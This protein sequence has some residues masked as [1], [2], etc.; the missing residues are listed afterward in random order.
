MHG[1]NIELKLTNLVSAFVFDIP[2]D[3]VDE[4]LV[5]KYGDI[6]DHA[7]IYAN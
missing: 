4:D 6:D 2:D 3:F 5:K 1:D 7:R